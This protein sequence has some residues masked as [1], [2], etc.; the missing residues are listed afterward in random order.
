ML[1]E[2]KT[3]HPPGNGKSF[4]PIA[5]G[6]AVTTGECIG[7][8]VTGTGSDQHIASKVRLTAFKDVPNSAWS[9][10]GAVTVGGRTYAVSSNVLCYNTRTKDWMTLNEAHATPL[11][12]T[13]MFT[14]V[15]SGSSRCAE[16]RFW[17]QRIKRMGARRISG[18]LPHSAGRAGSF[19]RQKEG[20]ARE[21]W[22]GCP[23]PFR[24]AA[25]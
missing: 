22:E 2:L 18:G 13:S 11:P 10:S 4:G 16:F 14:T 1:P 3:D 20:R 8:T 17:R 15:R 7:I 19:W 23:M 24:S 9:G 5:T 12:P 6:Y 25:F 21:T